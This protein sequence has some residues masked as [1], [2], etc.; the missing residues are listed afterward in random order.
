MRSIERRVTMK[1]WENMR[2]RR[3]SKSRKES[4]RRIRRRKMRIRHVKY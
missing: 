2:R 3:K 4:D 1:N